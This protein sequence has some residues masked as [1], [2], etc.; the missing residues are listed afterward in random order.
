MVGFQDAALDHV[1]NTGSSTDDDLG[2]ILQRAD[3]GTTN[4]SVALNTHEV[5]NGDKG[6][7]NLPSKLTAGN[8]IK[9]L[10]SLEVGVDSLKN[11][12]DRSRRRTSTRLR[13]KNNIVA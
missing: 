7:L 12:Q 8:K 13:L 3:T 11:G 9:S 6:L 1:V 4:R 10:A 5:T 2:A